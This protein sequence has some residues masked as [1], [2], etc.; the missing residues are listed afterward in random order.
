MQKILIISTRSDSHATIVAESLKEKGC[1]PILW[2]QDE[3]LLNQKL[4]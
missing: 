1:A 4:I 3:F 2:Y